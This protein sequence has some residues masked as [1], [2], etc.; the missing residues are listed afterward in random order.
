MSIPLAIEAAVPTPAVSLP[1]VAGRGIAFDTT[2]VDLTSAGYAEKEY[3]FAGNAQAYTNSQLLGTNGVWTVADGPSTPYVSR[4]LVRTPTDPA[5]FNG[6]VLVEWLNV[7]GGVDAAAEWDYSHVELLREGYAWVG[8]TTQ[9]AGAQFLHEFDSDRYASIQHPGDSW[10]YDIFSQAG[11]ALLH[12]NP[13]PLGALTPRVRSLIAEGESQ[14]AARMITYYNAIQPVAGV[15][16]GFLIHSAGAGAALSQSIAGAGVLGNPSF[17]KPDG[18]PATPDIAV[19]PTSFLRGDLQQPVLFFE[20]ETDVSVLGEGFSL[21]NQPDSRTF[22]LWEVAG[23]THADSYLLK[24]AAADAAQSGLPSSAFNCGSPPTNNGPD[25]TFG[26]RAA[27]RAISLWTR[28]PEISPAKAPRLSVQVVTSPTPAAVIQR[29]PATGDA[30]GG[31]RLPAVAVPIETLSGIRPP[32]AVAA[33]PTCIL[34]GAASP[35][36]GG[37]DS[38][39]GVAGIDPAPTPPPSL[40]RLYHSK[41]DYVIRYEFAT[42]ESVLERFALPEDASEMIELARDASV[43]QGS[44]SNAAIVPDP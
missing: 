40:A 21:H 31:I 6:T 8:V 29:D 12:G 28:F 4:M 19:P 38:W 15:Y 32:A 5:R 43:P 10:S 39:D 30:I 2:A 14:S 3:F 35:W 41:S 9:F 16:Q 20:T 17:P 26:I 22:R 1:A 37:T 42:L 33:N 23:T 11:M 36:D 24:W 13:R 25:E 44:A 18:V 34:F 7:S 27:T